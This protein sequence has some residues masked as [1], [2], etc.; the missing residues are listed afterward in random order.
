MLPYLNVTMRGLDY[1]CG[2]GPVL[3]QLVRKHGMVCE[4]YDPL[5]ADRSLQP[6]YDFIFATECFEHFLNPDREIQRLRNLLRSGGLLGIM[7]ECWTDVEQFG[8]WYYTKDPTHISFYHA[9]TL[10]Y[11]CNQYGFA[12][13][14]QKENRVFIL[15][16]HPDGG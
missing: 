8:R 11:I 7:T 16:G 10:D 9:D 13:L 2:P 4:D 5:F 12:L 6:P 15:E 14:W 1:G 3:S